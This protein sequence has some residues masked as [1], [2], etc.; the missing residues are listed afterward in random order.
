MK[1]PQGCI[2]KMAKVLKTNF[3][4]IGVISPEG[5]GRL[6]GSPLLDSSKMDRVR[7]NLRFIFPRILSKI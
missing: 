7:Q 6:G 3:C 2:K 1:S 5:C 4:N